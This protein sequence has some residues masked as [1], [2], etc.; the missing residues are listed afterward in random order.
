MIYLIKYKTHKLRI[1][2]FIERTCL[3]EKKFR[4][5]GGLKKV[6]VKRLSAHN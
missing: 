5:L 2:Y 1:Q 3:G 4:S 6:M